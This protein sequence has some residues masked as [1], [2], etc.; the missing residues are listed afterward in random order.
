MEQTGAC[1]LELIDLSDTPAEEV[2][3]AARR[4]AAEEAARPF[5][6]GRGPLLRATLLRLSESEHVLLVTM[7]H[8][9]SD[10]WSLGVLV[11]EVA[12]LYEAFAEGRESPLAELDIQYAD[13][14]VWQRE[15]LQGEVL[16]NLLDYWRGKLG[17]ALPELRLPLDHPRPAVRT[18]SGTHLTRHLPVELADEVRM[19]SRSEGS[20]VF[21]TL[22][23]AFQLLLSRYSQQEDILTGTAIANRNRGETEGLIGF[24]VNMLVM[25]TDLSGDPTFRELMRR[26]REVALGAYAHQDVPFERLVEEFAP[27]RNTSRTPL[28]Q[29]A[30][31]F[32]N[33]P[34]PA[35]HLPCLTLKPLEIEEDAGRFDLTLWLT[36]DAGT[37]AATWYYNT[38]LFEPAT[39][40]RTHGHFETLLRNITAQPE[41]CLSA[42]EMLTEEEKQQ[43][44]VERARRQESLSEK[45][46]SSRR[47]P[48]VAAPLTQPAT[49]LTP[50]HGSTHTGDSAS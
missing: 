44:S 39:I 50:V 43:Q 13:F 37:L 31:G 6:L 16:E 47:R 49:E 40:E 1:R 7:H 38:D 23:A 41:A 46:R 36:D 14:A 15:W 48:A 10:G 28:V 3:A 25:R 19:L 29:V 42:F 30:F 35:M 45:L 8:I 17:G 24:F 27:E 9:I 4:L 18:P 12:A 33:S 2:E 21:M 11:K 34:M 20:T 26:V 5:D 22:L 32:N